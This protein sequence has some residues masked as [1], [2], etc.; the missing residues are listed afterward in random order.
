MSILGPLAL[1]VA[2]SL[3]RAMPTKAKGFLSSL[4]HKV[5]GTKGEFPSGLLVHKILDN[6]GLEVFSCR[7]IKATNQLHSGGLLECGEPWLWAARL[8][9]IH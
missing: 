1:L 3:D 8:S 9:C 4:V 5:E 7:Q 2:S 6:N